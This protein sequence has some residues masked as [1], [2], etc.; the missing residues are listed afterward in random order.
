MEIEKL[1]NLRK[2]VNENGNNNKNIITLTSC[3]F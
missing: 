2:R 3:L 1:E